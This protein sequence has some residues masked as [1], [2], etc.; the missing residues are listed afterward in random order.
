M[1][2][3]ALLLGLPALAVAAVRAPGGRPERA[4]AAA[5]LLWLATGVVLF[6]AMARLHPRY[7]EGF[8]PAV[9]AAAGIGLAWVIRAGG[10]AARAL[11]AA[12]A[13]ALALYG[14][15]LLG[16]ASTVWLIGG[17]AAAVGLARGGVPGPPRRAQRRPRRRRSASPRFSSRPRWPPASPPTPSPTLASSG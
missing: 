9:A 10:P 3:A 13:V 15:Y 6:S 12:A 7:T 1:L 4:A 14:H 5:L 17:L 16:G 2:L 11:A 8:T